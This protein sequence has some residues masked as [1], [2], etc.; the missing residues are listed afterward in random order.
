[1]HGCC[2]SCP[3]D[4]PP[5]RPPRMLT[6]SLTPPP[7]KSQEGAGHA[8]LSAFV[9]LVFDNS[10][11]RFPVGCSLFGSMW[12]IDVVKVGMP[13][14]QPPPCKPHHA[15]PHAITRRP[16][17]P[18]RSTRTRCGCGAPSAPRR[19]STRSTAS[20]SRE[21]R[22]SGLHGACIDM[23]ACLGWRRTAGRLHAG[24]T[25][26]LSLSS[27]H[28]HHHR[29]PWP[30]FTTE[31]QA[32]GDEPARVGRLQPRQPLLHRAAGQGAAGGC[33][34]VFKRSCSFWISSL[35]LH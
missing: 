11:G 2:S 19:T 22:G 8:V 26:I 32:G 34:G 31:Q 20:T 17:P 18:L 10:D 21:P 7:P 15:N 5:H 27:P 12:P 4:P 13:S 23:H 14:M 29:A 30:L 28:P 35:Q 25:S 16:P 3:M 1:M 24:L 9:E 33:S 6:G